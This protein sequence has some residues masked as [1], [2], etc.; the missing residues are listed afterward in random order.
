MGTTN[1]MILCVGVCGACVWGCEGV[2]T[3]NDLPL[4][5]GCRCLWGVGVCGV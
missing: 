3:T 5:L 2:G 4:C 1:G